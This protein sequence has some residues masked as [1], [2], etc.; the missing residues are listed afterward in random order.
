MNY[1]EPPA[2][3]YGAANIH[4]EYDENYTYYLIEMY[5][6]SFFSG[7]GIQQRNRNWL[8]DDGWLYFVPMVS[9]NSKGTTIVRLVL[10][11]IRAA[12]SH[13]LLCS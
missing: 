3:G 1:D 13:Y 9:S 12:T 7:C 6:E 8:C 4:N 2:V 11:T 5:L 10:G